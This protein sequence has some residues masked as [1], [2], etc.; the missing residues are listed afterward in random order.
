MNSQYGV[1]RVSLN[2]R[3]IS[4]NAK[5][6]APFSLSALENKN[7]QV[8]S[9][10]RR[11]Q[12]VRLPVTC[13]RCRS[14]LMRSPEVR[15]QQSIRINRSCWSS[16]RASQLGQEIIMHKMLFKQCHRVQFNC[17]RSRQGFLTELMKSGSMDLRIA[18]FLCCVFKS[19]R[20]PS[21]AVWSYSASSLIWC[22]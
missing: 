9:K 20:S 8:E 10:P 11:F 21:F 13:R 5:L 17:V 1:E 16:K 22:A 14:H 6:W 3:L 18:S 7:A 19:E 15:S 12:L 2:Q 4:L